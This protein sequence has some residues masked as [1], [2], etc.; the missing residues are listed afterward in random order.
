[1]TLENFKLMMGSYFI[2]TN[3]VELQSKIIGVMLHLSNKYTET[4][5]LICSNASCSFHGL[6]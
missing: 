6:D 5:M 4:V 1:M 3:V 2:S